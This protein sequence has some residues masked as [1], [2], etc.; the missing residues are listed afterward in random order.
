MQKLI[1]AVLYRMFTLIEGLLNLL[2]LFVGKAFIRSDNDAESRK[3]KLLLVRTEKG[4]G[5]FVLFSAS[6]PAYRK[7]F[8]NC[9]I[10]LL[11]SKDTF[12]LA[13]TC[14]HVDEVWQ[15][16]IRKFRRRLSDRITWLVRLRNARFDVALNTSYSTSGR[17]L[18]CL[19]GWT[20]ATRRIAH[21]CIDK[22]GKRIRKGFYHTELVPNHT[23][24][25]FEIDRNFD[26]LRYLGYDGPI[27]VNTEIWL[28]DAD[29]QFQSNYVEHLSCDYAVLV[30]G[31]RQDYK[32]WHEV[33]FVNVVK[34]I[35]QI[36]KIK[37]L[38]CGSSAEA[39]ICG[40]ITEDLTRSSIDAVDLSG[41]TAL[42]EL[43]VIIS[44]AKFCF[45]NDTGSAHISCA[46]GV[47]TVIILG[48]GHYAR[49]FPYP[50]N[51][52]VYTVT[53]KLPCFNCYWH[54]I[55]NEMECITKISVDKVVNAVEI[56]LD[57]TKN[58]TSVAV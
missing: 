27:N 51:S 33:N 41:K 55:L 26:M 48:G 43:A 11:V 4:I 17:Y 35:N 5:D 28:T 15:I 14:P 58:S 47:P 45:G 18:D 30:P 40:R 12:N 38:V 23:Q 50:G 16:D 52:I 7:L 9:H 34:E 37:W 21:L 29:R 49:F 10:V 6:L 8:E 3:S 31:S 57:K 36:S 13:E 44:K 39:G 24:W 20:G 42:R 32:C 56:A 2:L 54:C 1:K 46:L 53:N 22:Y 25:K 19:I